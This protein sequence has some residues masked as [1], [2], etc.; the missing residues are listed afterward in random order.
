[1]AYTSRRPGIIAAIRGDSEAWMSDWIHLAHW[2]LNEA[3]CGSEFTPQGRFYWCREYKVWAHGL[4]VWVLLHSSPTPRSGTVVPR[5][6]CVRTW[7][8]WISR[9]PPSP[10]DAAD[11]SAISDIRWSPHH[12]HHTNRRKSIK[13]QI[14]GLNRNAL[15]RILQ[16]WQEVFHTLLNQ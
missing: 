12:A 10:P 4:E 16:I 13:I 3:K 9:K 5:S 14:I 15:A 8:L 2:R 7:L 11:Q 1:M 6:N